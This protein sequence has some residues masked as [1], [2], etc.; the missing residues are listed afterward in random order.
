M[1]QVS[2]L[3]QQFMD[4]HPSDCAR[5]LEQLDVAETCTLIQKVKPETAAPVVECMMT[6]YGA[7]C[8]RTLDVSFTTSIIRD[9]KMHQAARLLR[10]VD[11]KLSESI[12]HGLSPHVKSGLHASLRYP[13]KTVGRAMDSNPFSVWTNRTFRS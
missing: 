3:V 6:S 1:V 13:D 11:G 7:G 12:L 4:R 8:L 10:A 5:I 2:P 9:M